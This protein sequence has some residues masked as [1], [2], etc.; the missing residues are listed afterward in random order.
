VCGDI[1][2][3]LENIPTCKKKIKGKKNQSYKKLSKLIGEVILSEYFLD[4]ITHEK[5]HL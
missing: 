3:V 1:V 4:M 2:K 5:S